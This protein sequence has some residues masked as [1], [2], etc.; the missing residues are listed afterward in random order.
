VKLFHRTS[1][2]YRLVVQGGMPPCFFDQAA[3]RQAGRAAYG[4]D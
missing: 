1:P 4:L 3:A 2:C